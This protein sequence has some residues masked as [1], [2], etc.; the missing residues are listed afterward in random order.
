MQ[1]QGDDNSARQTVNLSADRTVRPRISRHARLLSMQDA[2]MA[3][4]HLLRREHQRA[5]KQNVV[6]DW[7]EGM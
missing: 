3:M 2:L 7:P 5:C 4:T 6:R 1:L